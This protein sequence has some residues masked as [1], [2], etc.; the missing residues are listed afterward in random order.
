M[1]GSEFFSLREAL[2][3]A[4]RPFGGVSV[5]ALGP[6]ADSGHFLGAR[7]L[8]ARRR[9]PLSLGMASSGLPFGLG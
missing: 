1:V 6:P 7:A 4:P 9:V 5:L 8:L 3:P 2:S